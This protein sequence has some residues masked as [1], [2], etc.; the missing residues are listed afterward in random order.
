MGG[1]RVPAVVADDLHADARLAQDGVVEGGDAR[2]VGARH[3]DVDRAVIRRRRAN[4]LEIARQAGDE[5][6]DLGL[7]GLAEKGAPLRPPGVFDRRPKLLGE[8]RDDPVLEA[9]AALVRERQVVGI[10]AYPQRARLRRAGEHHHC[11][12]KRC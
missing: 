2:A 9:L 10:G 1:R 8:K 4:A 3:E 7:Q 11:K 6:A 5:I 12:Y